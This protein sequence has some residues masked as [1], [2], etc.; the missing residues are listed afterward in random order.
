MRACFDVFVCV[1]VLFLIF[2]WVVGLLRGFIDSCC[3]QVLY[4][5]VC[6]LSS[7]VVLSFDIN[8]YIYTSN[9]LG[10][11]GSCQAS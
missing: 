2:V 6:F 5:T 7:D 10:L 1:S 8:I 9:M 3:S 11:I 4:L